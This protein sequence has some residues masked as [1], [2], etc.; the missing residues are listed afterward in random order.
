M[1]PN[2]FFNGLLGPDR[3]LQSVGECPADGALEQGAGR[4]GQAQA[5]REDLGQGRM[6]ATDSEPMTISPVV[7]M[8]AL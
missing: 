1:A 8:K 2:D 7:L 4:R 5:G 3:D 6:V